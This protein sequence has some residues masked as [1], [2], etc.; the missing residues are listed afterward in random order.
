MHF[1]I[2]I[3]GLSGLSISSIVDFLGQ[4]QVI[5]VYFLGSPWLKVSLSY[6]DVVGCPNNDPYA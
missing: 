2:D 5:Y 6:K 4:S 1:F 3:L